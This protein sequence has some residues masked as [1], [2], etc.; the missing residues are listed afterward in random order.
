[1]KSGT[2]LVNWEISDP[3]DVGSY[4]LKSRLTICSLNFFAKILSKTCKTLGLTWYNYVFYQ[5]IAAVILFKENFKDCNIP[6]VDK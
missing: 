5:V 4:I 2:Y 6:N 1:M 3:S